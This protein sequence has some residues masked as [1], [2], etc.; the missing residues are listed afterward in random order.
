ML[1]SDS[2]FDFYV[3][4]MRDKEEINP[5]KVIN[6]S[7]SELARSGRFSKFVP[8]VN[9][10]VPILKCTHT[11]SGINCDLNFS[12]SLGVFNSPILCHLLQ[13]DSRIYVLATIIKFWMKVHDCSGSNYI[14]NYAALWM[15]LF[16]L[17]TLPQPIL[18]P[19]I[20]FQKNAPE[21]MIASFNFGFNY[22]LPNLS[23]NKMRCSEILL[24]FFEYYRAFDFENNVISPLY[25]KVIPKV[26]IKAKTVPE[27]AHYEEI[28]QQNTDETPMS[29]N[30]PLC[31]Q[32][33]FEITHSIPGLISPKVFKDIIAKFGIAIDII[34]SELSASG[35]SAK[36]LLSLFDTSKF[37]EELKKINRKDLDA[38]TS[39]ASKFTFSVRPNEFELS[40]TREIL[41]KICQN[42][43]E[44]ISTEQLNQ[45]WT[46]K[47]IYF[48]MEI[49]QDIF[50]FKIKLKKSDDEDALFEEID[51]SQICTVNEEKFSYELIV[52]G[53]RDVFYARK[54]IKDI[55]SSTLERE[56]EISKERFSNKN[57]PKINFRVKIKISANVEK[58][59]EISIEIIDIIQRRHNNYYRTFCT[60]IKQQFQ[61]LM[62][63]YFVHRMSYNAAIR[64]LLQDTFSDKQSDGN[65]VEEIIVEG[66]CNGEQN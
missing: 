8:I 56:I 42:G 49:I 47:T 12:D 15:L 39:G 7:K 1:I 28:L 27:F 11:P 20:E 58:F 9:A 38:T 64:S 13:F 37:E 2:D 14:T 10:R 61:F 40:K 43:N 57:T 26:D 59:N 21:Y 46:Q 34:K 44:K 4:V 25:A 33:P 31:I 32:D 30:K 29:L 41:S 62:K 23:K 3:E 22:R 50:M 51:A 63:I 45:S 65:E 60:T 48:F 17:Q 66:K 19:I 53:I 5:K 18:P 6:N 16:Y 54:L 24:G 35:E 36:L 52:H 55:D